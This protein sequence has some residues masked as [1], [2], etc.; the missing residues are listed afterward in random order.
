MKKLFKRL[1]FE[2]HSK[3][4]LEDANYYYERFYLIGDIIDIHSRGNDIIWI[5]SS[6]DQVIIS[7]TRLLDICTI[8]FSS[9]YIEV[10][11]FGIGFKWHTLR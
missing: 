8:I 4:I 1:G 11:L 3:Y 7:Y 6:Y 9:T 2:F 10:K 5:R